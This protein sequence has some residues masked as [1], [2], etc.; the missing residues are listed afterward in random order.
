MFSFPFILTLVETDVI[1][2]VKNII[3]VA[4][5]RIYGHVKPHE[6]VKIYWSRHFN[7]KKLLVSGY[8]VALFKTNNTNQVV[9]MLTIEKCVLNPQGKANLLLAQ[10]I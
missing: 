9:E 2:G 5:P 8:S 10:T 1:A 3:K 6:V 4:L 7:R